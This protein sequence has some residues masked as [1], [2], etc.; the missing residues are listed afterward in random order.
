MLL[1]HT[2]AIVQLRKEM[3]KY[4]LIKGIVL[5]FVF[6]YAV[7]IASLYWLPI[8]TRLLSVARKNCSIDLLAFSSTSATKEQ[9]MLCQKDAAEGFSGMIKLFDLQSGIL[10]TTALVLLALCIYNSALL[11]K[12][13]NTF[14]KQS[15]KSSHVYSAVTQPS[16]DSLG[17]VNSR[18]TDQE[19]T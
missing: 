13:I 16:S 11:W 6:S 10:N 12:Q 4:L 5:A 3:K 7:I 2:H 1:R 14:R 17:E 19:I 18:V 9:L 15:G 8:Y